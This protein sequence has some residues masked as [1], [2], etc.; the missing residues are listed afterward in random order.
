MTHGMRT[1][2]SFAAPRARPRQQARVSSVHVSQ[3]ITTTIALCLQQQA[4]SHDEPRSGPSC[5][6]IS[7]LLLYTS[8]AAGGLSMPTAHGPLEYTLRA[9]MAARLC[10]LL[11]THTTP[12][13]PRGSAPST[14][15]AK[16]PASHT[17]EQ[18]RGEIRLP[19]MQ[20]TGCI[21]WVISH[22][23]KSL[24]RPAAPTLTTTTTTQTAYTAW[25][26]PQCAA[27]A[28]REAKHVREHPP[29]ALAPTHPHVHHPPARRHRVRST[30]A[31]WR[32]GP[33]TL[34]LLLEQWLG[35]SALS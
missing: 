10:F 7:W 24:P 29:T 5:T 26:T 17:R 27:E 3:S 34:V 13:R 22:A 8:P 4:C 2:R 11:M 25:D 33:L 23:T 1:R 21:G 6:I 20:H 32:G 15:V 28:I 14:C 12:P 16:R 18:H 9:M 35:A 31:A 19:C 30:N